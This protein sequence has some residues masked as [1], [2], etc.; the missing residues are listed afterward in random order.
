MSFFN[1]SKL[2]KLICSSILVSCYSFSASTN[3]T[4]I[5]TADI[6]RAKN[7]IAMCIGCHGIFNYKASFPIVYSVPIIKGQNAK[8]IEKSLQDYKEGKRKHPTM[9]AIAQSLTDQDI[10]DISTYYSNVKNSNLINTLK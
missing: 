5:K 1:S 10:I 2:I 4:E 8:Y 3:A 6:N 9:R 7:K